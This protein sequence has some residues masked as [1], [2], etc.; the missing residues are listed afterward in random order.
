MLR[1]GLAMQESAQNTV[2]SI[3]IEVSVTAFRAVRVTPD[4]KT[5][6]SLRQE[7]RPGGETLSQ[8]LGFIG[9]LAEGF[10]EFRRAGLAVPGLIHCETNRVA[11]SANVPELAQFDLANEIRIAAGVETLI[12]NDANAAAF[13]EFTLGAGR[14]SEN[15]FYAT[16]GAGVGGALILNKEVWRG[17]SGFAGEFGYFAI[18]SDG[19][20]L[21][22]VASA[23]N[24][25]RRTRDRFHQDSTS[26][27]NDLPE[28]TITITDIVSAA[29]A[30]DDFS[31]L[32][33]ER[34]GT[35]VGTAV[36]SVINLLNIEKIVVGGET[37]D[38]KRI[39][40]DA[41][42][43]RARELSFAPSFK[44]TQIVPG[45]LGEFAAAIGA[46][47]LARE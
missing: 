26:S 9:G 3:G 34:T 19:M 35:Y 36:A 22:E 46:A 13:G 8:L 5:V 43:R 30:E 10:G 29:E 11:F 18:N 7:I 33:L 25:V 28:D 21:E 4:G 31:K 39:V 24:I 38:K 17:D 12:E 14:G 42:I 1:H 2:D 41:L 23:P 27:L 44:K 32:M 20:R 47:L 16:L 37:I 45:E 6:K 40:L 15:L